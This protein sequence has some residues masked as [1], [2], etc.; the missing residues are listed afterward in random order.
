MPMNG[1]TDAEIKAAM[2]EKKSRLF[3]SNLETADTVFDFDENFLKRIGVVNM[4][5]YYL[6]KSLEV[7]TNC[8][9]AYF[10]KGWENARG[11][12]LEHDAAKAYGLEIIY[13]K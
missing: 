8:K 4:P 1:R 3:A 11:C 7:M 2:Y 6:A 13:E 12:R 10:C 5:L 9:V